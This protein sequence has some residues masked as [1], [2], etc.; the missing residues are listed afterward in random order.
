M[1]YRESDK[2]QVGGLIWLGSKID[3]EVKEVRGAA[4]C[5]QRSPSLARDGWQ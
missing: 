4:K 2:T 3:V 5:G 1:C